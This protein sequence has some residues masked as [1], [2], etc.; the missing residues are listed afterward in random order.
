MGAPSDN[1]SNSRLSTG[2]ICT[3]VERS[4]SP[5]IPIPTGEGHQVS[6]RAST[7][8]A[9]IDTFRDLGAREDCNQPF[10]GSDLLI[11]VLNIADLPVKVDRGILPRFPLRIQS[12]LW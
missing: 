2:P 6:S 12:I 9:L 8:D 10:I 5:Y 11:S 7:A 4:S 3:P 1:F